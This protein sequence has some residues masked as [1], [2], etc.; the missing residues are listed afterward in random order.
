MGRVVVVLAAVL[1]R[2]G[3]SFSAAVHGSLT[4]AGAHSRRGS[5]RWDEGPRSERM[6]GSL[7]L[8][9]LIL[10][11][12]SVWFMHLMFTWVAFFIRCFWIR[13]VDGG[14]AEMGELA[15]GHGTGSAAKCGGLDG[16]SRLA[17]AHGVAGGMGFRWP[18]SRATWALMAVVIRVARVVCAAP[19][20]NGAARLAKN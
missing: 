13:V 7:G 8:T 9:G 12:P 18:R 3:G 5:G 11:V 20:G 6:A 19:A 1:Y 2:I 4:L 14:K 10:A 15:L 17:V 16:C